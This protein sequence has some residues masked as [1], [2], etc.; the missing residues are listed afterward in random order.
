MPKPPTRMTDAF[1]A[2]E[3][4]HHKTIEVVEKAAYDAVVKSEELRTLA[5]GDP[6]SLRVGVVDL[7][8]SKLANERGRVVRIYLGDQGWMDVGFKD[9]R[10]LADDLD[11]CLEWDRDIGDPEAYEGHTGEPGAGGIE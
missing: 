5:M 11:R 2:C 10:Q 1:W 7:P 6:N 8:D 4:C 3:T 9:A